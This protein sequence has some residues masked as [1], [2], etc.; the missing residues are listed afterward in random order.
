M[1]PGSGHVQFYME[2]CSRHHRGAEYP[3]D[4]R[5]QTWLLKGIPPRLRQRGTAP[6]GADR[7]RC[8]RRLGPLPGHTTTPTACTPISSSNQA[9]RFRQQSI[10]GGKCLSGAE[11]AGRESSVGRQTVV[12]TPREENGP[13][14]LINM[15]KSSPV[16]RHTGIVDKMAKLSLKSR[17]TG[18]SA[19][20]QGV[21][22][23]STRIRPRMAPSPPQLEIGRP[24]SWS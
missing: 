20:D 15:R 24:L 14:R 11:P 9:A 6:I 1:D 23:T 5:C 18:A 4:R 21:R 17:P 19:A 13:F 10:H 12:E 22:P 16:E 2:R 3:R 7:L 8:G